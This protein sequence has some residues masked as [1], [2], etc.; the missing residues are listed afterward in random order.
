MAITYSYG[1]AAVTTTEATVFT[2]TAAQAVI[3]TVAVC[4][5]S[6]TNTVN[7]NLFVKPTAATTGSTSNAFVYGAPIPPNTT[8]TWT[9]GIGLAPNNVLSA[10]ASAAGITVTAF[11]STAS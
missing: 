1:Q 6:S 2:A 4:N 7:I 10:S 3:S 9:L 5:T 11:G 8:V